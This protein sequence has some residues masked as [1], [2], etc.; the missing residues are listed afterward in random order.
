[1]LVEV[2]GLGGS[3]AEGMNLGMGKAKE[4]VEDHGAEGCAEID[5]FLRRCVEF[6]TLVRG[7]D[8]ENPHVMAGG[9]FD[10]VPIRLVN[11]VPMQVD[12]IELIGFDRLHNHVRGSVGGKSDVAQF[13]L[14][15][16]FVGD[17]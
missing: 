8:D 4:V 1:M 14:G 13:A 5:Q 12:V 6:S 16:K 7:A 10:R 17:V 11:V 2:A 9:G 3:E 15:L